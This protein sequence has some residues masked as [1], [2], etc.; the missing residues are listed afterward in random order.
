MNEILIETPPRTI[1]EVY[2]GLP[3]G[4]RAELIDKV[5]YM[6]P[7]PVSKHQV[8]LNKINVQLYNHLEKSGT[9]II[10]VSP[11]DVYLDEEMNAVQPDLSV[12]LKNGAAR[13]DENGYI[14]GAPDLIVEILSPGNANYDLVK[15]RELY[16]RFGVKEYWIVDP[17]T[18]QTQGFQLKNGK[19]VSISDQIGRME[20]PL[21]AVALLF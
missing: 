7:S 3:K 4:T 6:S 12:I 16:E 13:V 8:V 15:K 2:K 10:Y 21:L 18:K 19:Y 20:S 9:G 11:L 5:I 17:D 14:H 1:M